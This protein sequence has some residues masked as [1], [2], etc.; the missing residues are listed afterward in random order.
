MTTDEKLPPIPSPPTISESYIQS[1]QINIGDLLINYADKQLHTVIKNESRENCRHLDEIREQLRNQP[2]LLDQ[3]VQSFADYYSLL[4]NLITGLDISQKGANL[5]FKWDKTNLPIVDF[6]IAC[7]GYNVVI[8]FLKIAGRIKIDNEENLRSFIGVINPAKAILSKVFEIY[9]DNFSPTL[10][11]NMLQKLSNFLDVYWSYAT[12]YQTIFADKGLLSSRVMKALSENLQTIGFLEL[13]S[14]F[15]AFASLYIADW[16]LEKQKYADALGYANQFFDK[17]PKTDPKQ[18]KKGQQTSPLLKPFMN[19]FNPRY[20][21]LLEDNKQIY[22]ETPSKVD[23]IQKLSTPFKGKYNWDSHYTVTSLINILPSDLVDII[24]K[25][26]D[27]LLIQ[28]N[29]AQSDIAEVLS[30]VPESTENE[31]NQ[32]VSELYSK[33]TICQEKC[34]SISFLLGQ[35]THAISHR[36]PNAFEQFSQLRSSFDQAA[37]SDLYY[38]TEYGKAK[39][40]IQ[41]MKEISQDLQKSNEAIQALIKEEKDIYEKAIED[42]QTKDI[43]LLMSVNSSFN[44]SFDDILSKLSVMF[45]KIHKKTTLMRQEKDRRIQHY[46][47]IAQT[48]RSGFE[49]GINFYTQILT[50]ITNLYNQVS[51]C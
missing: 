30:F 34:E 11:K 28:V 15:D 23:E 38:E 46:N 22:F 47:T 18:K 50:Q 32:M 44:K 26:H 2:E 51:S 21:Q 1:H 20:N 9:R 27:S 6:D 39:S 7:M 43:T 19:Y 5:Q 49:Q 41:S 10:T 37:S 13:S 40:E 29:N 45:P 25:K 24:K 12:M 31:I 8:G 42:I 36:Y 4:T 14:F 16:S 35:K 3:R 48:V 33:R 17:L